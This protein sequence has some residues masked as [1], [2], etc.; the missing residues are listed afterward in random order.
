MML[1]VLLLHSFIPSFLSSF[2]HFLTLFLA[3]IWI[4]RTFAHTAYHYWLLPLL[5][6]IVPY[7]QFPYR[8]FL[9]LLILYHHSIAIDSWILFFVIWIYRYSLFVIL[10]DKKNGGRRISSDWPPFFFVIDLSTIHLTSVFFFAFLVSS[11]GVIIQYLSGCI[12]QYLS[13]CIFLFCSAR[14]I[15]IVFSLVV[16]FLKV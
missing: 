1:F 12:I 9:S 7:M 11:F 13:G 3:L 5:V 6:C 14:T 8:S 10:S 4:Y 16:L 15:A 2:L